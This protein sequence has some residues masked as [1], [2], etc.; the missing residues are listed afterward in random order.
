M[1]KEM[2]YQDHT[3]MI[4]IQSLYYI[5]GYVTYELSIST[6]GFSGICNFCIPEDKI[7]DYIV[8]IDNMISS[9]SG[10]IEI[11]DC[12]SDAYLKLFFE[13][14]MNFYVLGQIGGSYADNTLKF[15]LK[16][17]QTVLQGMKEKLLDYVST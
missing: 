3:N 4:S 8:V 11:H 15:K 12:E 9:L 6:G 5:G 17:D 10:E 7:E 13:D 14:T 1:D 2:I 16:A